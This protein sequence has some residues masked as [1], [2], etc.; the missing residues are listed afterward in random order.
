MGLF[1]RSKDKDESSDDSLFEKAFGRFTK[2]KVDK[3][4][5]ISLEHGKDVRKTVAKGRNMSY[6]RDN[7]GNDDGTLTDE[8]WDYEELETKGAAE[9]EF[10]TEY[11]EEHGPV[12]PNVKNK[13]WKKSYSFGSKR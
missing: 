5:R 8:S 13:M 1:G 7:T 3:L 12:D 10:R 9:D 11:K 2:L 6:T 4:G